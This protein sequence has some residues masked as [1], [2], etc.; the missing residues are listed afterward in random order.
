MKRK[1]PHGLLHKRVWW[2]QSFCWG[3]FFPDD[4]GLCKVNNNNNLSR[5]FSKSQLTLEKQGGGWRVRRVAVEYFLGSWHGHCARDLTGTGH[6]SRPAHTPHTH[7][8]THKHII[9]L[10]RGFHKTKGWDK[11]VKGVHRIIT[12]CI[13]VWNCQRFKTFRYRSV[14][15]VASCLKLKTVS[16]GRFCF[17]FFLREIKVLVS[18]TVLGVKGEERVEWPSKHQFPPPCE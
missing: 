8:R 1:C 17:Y 14:Q 10:P 3:S 15:V 4:P 5:K 2:R 16:L 9:L 6:Q 18:H 11:R 7:K 13:P 12:H